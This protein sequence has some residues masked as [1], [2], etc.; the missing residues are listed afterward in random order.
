MRF[1]VFA[2]ARSDH[3]RALSVCTLS[4]LLTTFRRPISPARLYSC[5]T[6]PLSITARPR[7]PCVASAA[8]ADRAGPRP[9]RSPFLG[10]LG[11]T[12]RRACF[13]KTAPRRAPAT[14]WSTVSAS[15][16]P[17]RPTRCSTAAAPP[18]SPSPPLRSSPLPPLP[19]YPPDMTLCV[20]PSIA[21]GTATKHA[22][23]IF[24]PER[25]L[26]G[27]AILPCNAPTHFWDILARDLFKA[28]PHSFFVALFPRCTTLTRNSCLQC[29]GVRPGLVTMRERAPAR[30]LVL[31]GPPGRAGVGLVATET[32]T[33]RRRYS[34]SLSSYGGLVPPA[35]FS[36]GR[37][38]AWRPTSPPLRHVPHAR[39]AFSCAAP[40]K[41]L[42]PRLSRFLTL[43]DPFRYT[44]L[45]PSLFSLHPPLDCSYRRPIWLLWA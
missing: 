44:G 4:F 10:T 35:R 5:A 19:F 33:S 22:E 30:Y 18:S 38:A 43:C 6:D 24:G 21:R 32:S 37:R 17:G 15:S 9:A 42:I 26:P 11:P 13:S 1:S 20:R 41:R 3:A 7:E 12:P 45:S 16:R 25:P 34:C 8:L 14:S 23:F 36:R 2:A 31:A 39:N 28:E 29:L 40:E 27:S